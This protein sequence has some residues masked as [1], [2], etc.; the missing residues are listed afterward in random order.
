MD[1][2]DRLSE[3]SRNIPRRASAA[4]D[5]P[6]NGQ[7]L[8]DTQG[9]TLLPQVPKQAYQTIDHGTSKKGSVTVRNSIY[10]QAG[11]SLVSN[12]SINP[13]RMLP[14]CSLQVREGANRTKKQLKFP[15]SPAFVN[16]YK[17]NRDIKVPK[18]Q[19]FCLDKNI[20]FNSEEQNFYK[21]KQSQIRF[22]EFKN[23]I[24][25]CYETARPD[26]V[27]TSLQI[28][29]ENSKAPLPPENRL[30]ESFGDA[31]LYVPNVYT[32]AH[33][34]LQLSLKQQ[35]GKNQGKK[36]IVSKINTHSPKPKRMRQAK[37]ADKAPDTYGQL[38]EALEGAH[39]MSRKNMLQAFQS[40]EKIKE[41][42]MR[43]LGEKMGA[44]TVVS[45]SKQV[46]LVSSSVESLMSSLSPGDSP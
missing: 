16:I 26:D 3:K 4:T 30:T 24:N 40:G 45:P 35:S 34:K 25:S 42:I 29:D 2:A 23:S 18:V 41:G 39:E 6:N 7:Y 17:M 20:P 21:L 9:S 32:Q 8:G 33:K 38:Y 46:K 11:S 19:E 36:K 5:F 27:D 22:K 1:Q 13:D 10:R 31:R 43:N 14:P 15:M 12:T 44:S 28:L 37:Q